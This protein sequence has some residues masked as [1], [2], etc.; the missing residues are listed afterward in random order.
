VPNWPPSNT[1]YVAPIGPMARTVAAAALMLSVMAGPHDM[2]RTSLPDAPADYVGRLRGGVRGRRF[3]LSPTLGGLRV[4]PDVAAVVTGAARAFEEA[5]AIV[6]EVP[7]PGFADLREVIRGLWSAHEAG[8]YARYLPEWRERMDPGLVACIEDG[9]RLG[10]LEYL[11]LREGK[12]AAPAGRAPA[13]ERIIDSGGVMPIR[14]PGG[15]GR[16]GEASTVGLR[17]WLAVALT[18]LATVA[19]AAP[20]AASPERPGEPPPGRPRSGLTV[21]DLSVVKLNSRVVAGARSAAILGAQ[22]EGSGVV[23]SPDGL[24]L[25]IGYLILEAETIELSTVDGR[26]VPATVV[27]YDSASGFGLVRALQPLGVGPVAFG[28]SA[29]IADREP[30]L[31]VGFDGVAPALVVSR[32]P[33]VGYWEYLLD[34]AIYTAPATVNWSGAALLSRSGQ[35]LGIGSLAVD[36]AMGPG[37]HVPGNLFVPIDLLKP[38]LHDLVARGKP[39]TPPRPWLGV[40]TQEVEGN[41]IVTRVSPDSPAEAAPLRPGDVI[42]RLG[43]E[44]VRG[45]AE[46]YKRLW[47]RGPAGVEVPLEVLRRG[48]LE[49]VTVKSIDR[50]RYYRTRPTF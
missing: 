2:D 12:N 49:T 27:G 28:E 46:F 42:V 17:R 8:M 16:V 5:G 35:L 30:V 6:D 24:V 1:D 18:L 23:I 50:D 33:Y 43:G 39:S 44:L 15:R 34:E 9:A 21:N 29:T 36:D 4:D 26:T 14:K 20:L 48:R 41:V 11:A 3:A 32:R 25:T 47:A 38:L 19:P 31:I 40:Q 45:Q 22:R 37:S 13:P 10:L 7:D